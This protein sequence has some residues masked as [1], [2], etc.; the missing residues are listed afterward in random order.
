M[1]A[2][3]HGR[4]VLMHDCMIICMYAVAETHGG[5]ELQCIG[6]SGGSPTA[7]LHLDTAVACS[8]PSSDYCSDTMPACAAGDESVGGG[9][10]IT[11]VGF[12]GGSMLFC[13]CIAANS[14]A[15]SSS[16]CGGGAGGCGGGGGGC[17]G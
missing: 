2:N 5:S 14:K 4:D 9:V 12:I 13:C 3:Y 17:G 10:W 1:I 11:I 8:G 7:S 16:G 15:S 6:Y